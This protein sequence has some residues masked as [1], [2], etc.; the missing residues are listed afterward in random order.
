MSI[1]HKGKSHCDLCRVLVLS[2]PPATVLARDKFM[3]SRRGS[4]I[5]RPCLFSVPLL[6][7]R[8]RVAD[9]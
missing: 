6:R 4:L 1:E 8:A 7:G 9:G 3:V 2:D 5:N